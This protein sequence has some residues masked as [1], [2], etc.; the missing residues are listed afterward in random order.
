M[1]APAYHIAAGQQRFQLVEIA[2]AFCQPMEILGFGQGTKECDGV[3]RRCRFSERLRI[4]DD[5]NEFMRTWPRNG[6]RQETFR[7][8]PDFVTGFHFRGWVFACFCLSTKRSPCSARDR[9]VVF[10]LRASRRARS[11]KSSAISIVVFINMAAHTCIEML[12]ISSGIHLLFNP[13]NSSLRASGETG[14]CLW[15]TRA[16]IRRLGRVSTMLSH[17]LA[18]TDNDKVARECNEAER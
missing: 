12:P 3:A 11:N 15:R 13:A 16:A 17:Q 14:D 10:S 18:R 8:R 5:G 2:W 4:R 1:Y 6:P 9:K 7:Q